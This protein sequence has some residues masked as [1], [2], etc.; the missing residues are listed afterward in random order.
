MQRMGET[1]ADVAGTAAASLGAI[2]PEANKVKGSSAPPNLRRSIGMILTVILPLPAQE[3]TLHGSRAHPTSV[4][5]EADTVKST[6]IS[7]RTPGSQELQ[8]AGQR[9]KEA[10]IGTAEHVQHRAAGFPRSPGLNPTET[11]EQAD[12][13][14]GGG[15]EA[16]KREPAAA[17]QEL[18]SGEVGHLPLCQA[19]AGDWDAYW[20]ACRR[21]RRSHCEQCNSR[22]FPGMPN[23]PQME[24]P[25]CSQMAFSVLSLICRKALAW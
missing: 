9:V 12:R 20:L 19:L 25:G 23:Q 16:A 14:G 15:V 13:G 5:K 8:D 17:S 7:N 24:D 22:H 1:A 2:I 6:D 18:H 11:A 3:E 21:K 10:A 4:E